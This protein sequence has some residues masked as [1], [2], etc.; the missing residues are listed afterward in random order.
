M[1]QSKKD[2][3]GIALVIVESPAKAKTIGKYLG[4]RYVVEASVGHVRDLPKGAKE[5][6]D[7]YKK[8]AWAR[9]GV[10]VDSNFEPIYVVPDEKSKQI[11]KLKSLLKTASSLYLATDEDREG[12]AISWHLLETLKPR[13]PVR[14]LV[15]HEITKTAILN[16]LENPREVDERLVDAQETRRVLDRLYG[17]EASPLLWYKIRNNLSAGRV[18]SVAVRLVVDRERERVAFN[19]ADYWDVLGVF[20]PSGKRPFS[21]TLTSLGGKA[22]PVGKDFN[23]AT[24]KLAKPEKFALLDE[25]EEPLT[26]LEIAR[27]MYWSGRPN[28]EVFAI[29]DVGARVEFLQQLGLI[30]VANYD[31]ISVAEPALR[32]R[33]S[34]AD[35]ESAENTVEQIFGVNGADDEPDSVERDANLGGD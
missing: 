24:G 1:I 27:R 4:D 15:F 20:S 28:R 35:A 19:S 18:Q 25:A 21:A 31:E 12:E 7:E 14:R 16:A 26:T 9:L 33:N 32:F 2:E 22:I 17:Y 23:P 13:V 11:K 6:P 10:N 29:S 30:S 8:E 5:I 3:D 34:F